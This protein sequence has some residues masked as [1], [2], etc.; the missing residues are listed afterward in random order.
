[1]RPGTDRDTFGWSPIEMSISTAKFPQVLDKESDPKVK[2]SNTFT[3][4]TAM[5]SLTESTTLHI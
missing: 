4:R 3:Y 5:L 2:V 1:M